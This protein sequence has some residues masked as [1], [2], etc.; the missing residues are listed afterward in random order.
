MLEISQICDMG[1]YE[2][3]TWSIIFLDVVHLSI[4]VTIV[5]LILI[6]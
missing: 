1:Y 4:N 3:F 5:A 2:I 6:P